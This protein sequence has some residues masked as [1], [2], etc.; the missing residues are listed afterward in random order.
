M[1]LKALIHDIGMKMKSTAHC[2]SIQCIRVGRFGIEDALLSKHWKLQYLME[3]LIKCTRTY[4][5][6]Y[7]SVKN[8][9]LSLQN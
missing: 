2:I 6:H 5:D 7:S 8:Q 4:K 9:Q 3:N 1:Y